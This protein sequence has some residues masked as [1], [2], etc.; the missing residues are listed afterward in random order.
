M[1]Q[2]AQSRWQPV[3]QS[4]RHPPIVYGWSIAESGRQQSHGRPYGDDR[5]GGSVV[6]NRR[7]ACGWARSLIQSEPSVSSEAGSF[8]R[9][10]K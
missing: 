9:R 10:P 7:V 8:I 1:T 5:L 2:W 3:E 6:K 4:V